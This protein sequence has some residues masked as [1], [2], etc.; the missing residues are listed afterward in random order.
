MTQMSY[1]WDW[2]KKDTSAVPTWTYDPYQWG[3]FPP[4]WY[5]YPPVFFNPKVPYKCPVCD[6]TGLVSR[7]PGVPGDVDVWTTTDTGPYGC[8]VCEG[9]GIVWSE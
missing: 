3:Q 7:P 9:K 8:R 4:L 5:T 6:G 1:N 2:D